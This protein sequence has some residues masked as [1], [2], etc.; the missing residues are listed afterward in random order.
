MESWS[1][2]TIRSKILTANRII[3]AL[4]LCA[5][6]FALFVPL[7]AQPKK[8]PR[9]GFMSVT[10]PATIPARIEAFRQSLRDLG[11]EDGK[12]IKIEFRYADG[13][14]DRVRELAA[15]LIALN[16]DVIVSGGGG[17][18]PSGQGSDFHCSDCHG[19]RY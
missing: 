15:E 12:N 14:L 13:K 16:V 17:G 10:S 8:V 11:Y 9:I 6:L 2:G 19:A 5:L 3:F 7:Q 1:V 18:N 4:T